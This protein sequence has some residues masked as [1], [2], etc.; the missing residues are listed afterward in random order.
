MTL[1]G[2]GSFT[3]MYPYFGSLALCIFQ[4]LLLSG[5][6]MMRW[7]FKAERASC[8]R[9]RPLELRAA[10]GEHNPDRSLIAKLVQ[11]FLPV[12]RARNLDH[13]PRARGHFEVSKNFPFRVYA[14]CSHD[15]AKA[16]FDQTFDQHVVQQEERYLQD[17]ALAKQHGKRK[18]ANLRLALQALVC[19]LLYI[20]FCMLDCDRSISMLDCAYF[21]FC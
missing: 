14:L 10:N 1:D 13:R 2:T 17:H 5:R 18:T 8:T 9:V 15:Q 11:R 4:T 12:H 20:T 16:L 3:L 21:V 6:K 7:R 19:S